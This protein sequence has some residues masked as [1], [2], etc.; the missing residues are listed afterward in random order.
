M[1]EALRDFWC[2]QDISE[3]DSLNNFYF[4]AAG[5]V[6]AVILGFIFSFITFRENDNEDNSSRK[7]TS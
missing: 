5:A 1:P 4:G 3:A 7:E 6:L 2:C